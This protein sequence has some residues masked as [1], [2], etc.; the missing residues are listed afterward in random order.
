MIFAKN[1][2]IL[3]KIF[4][5]FYYFFLTRIDLVILRVTPL[6]ILLTHIDILIVNKQ[7]VVAHTICMICILYRLLRYSFFV[8]YIIFLFKKKSPI[9]RSTPT[10]SPLRPEASTILWAI[11]LV[12]RSGGLKTD[13]IG[14][15]D[16][17]SDD[18]SIFHSLT[19]LSAIVYKEFNLAPDST[20]LG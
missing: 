3:H 5:F 9:S 8:C 2:Y 19:S 17:Q 4:L 12:R 14:K 10:C 1:F 18:S 11:Q 20:I 16:F 15:R 13:D 6:R 7:N